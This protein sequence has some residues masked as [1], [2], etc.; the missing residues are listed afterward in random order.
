MQIALPP[1][2]T[3]Y[4]TPFLI[5]FDNLFIPRQGIS[6]LWARQFIHTMVSHI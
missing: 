4:R 2:V 1:K 3:G 5:L 6:N